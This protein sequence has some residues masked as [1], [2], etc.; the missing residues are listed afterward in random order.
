MYL[1]HHSRHRR[2]HTALWCYRSIRTS[3]CFAETS[4]G[5]KL[6]TLYRIQFVR[7][8]KQKIELRQVRRTVQISVERDRKERDGDNEKYEAATKIDGQQ[9]IATDKDR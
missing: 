7:S 1:H 9:Q 8:R 5:S 6:D 4:S 3:I 2:K